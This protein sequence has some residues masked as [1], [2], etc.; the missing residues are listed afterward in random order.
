MILLHRSRPPLRC[1]PTCG[2]REVAGDLLETEPASEVLEASL[3]GISGGLPQVMSCGSC[4]AR[5]VPVCNIDA[6]GNA[7]SIV[8]LSVSD[9]S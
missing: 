2:Q 7:S 3:G 1:D 8:S 9:L 4:V 5:L 6:N